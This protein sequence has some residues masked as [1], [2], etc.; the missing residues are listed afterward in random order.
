MFGGNDAQTQQSNDNL[1]GPPPTMPM[2]D[3]S[4]AHDPAVHS[5]IPGM[6]QS[7]DVGNTA[8]DYSA[9]DE[10]ATD[11]V[12]PALPNDPIGAPAITTDDGDGADQLLDIKRNALQQLSPLLKHLDQTPEE[13]F[14]T[15]MMMLQASDDK[16]LVRPGL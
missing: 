14:R 10:P 12:Q 8:G 11:S 15:T 16:K 4:L 5:S 7:T 2:P 9:N 6:P 13:R 3:A 1:Q